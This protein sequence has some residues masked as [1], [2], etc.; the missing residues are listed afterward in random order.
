MSRR[1][2]ATATGREELAQVRQRRAAQ[3]H[4]RHGAAHVRRGGGT[5]EQPGGRQARRR[6]P[7][8]RA[9]RHYD[10]GVRERRTEADE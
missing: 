6:R 10:A 5:D 4:D 1:R 9:D 2:S 7:E 8:T 3:L